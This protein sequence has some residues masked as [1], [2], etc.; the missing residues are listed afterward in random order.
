MK[1]AILISG[2]VDSSVAL[3]LLKQARH[4]VTAF[5]LK[6]WLED[7]LA[8]L[9]DCP[10][11]EDLKYA[12][13]VCDQLQVPLNVIPL[14]KEYWDRV[15]AYTIAEVKAG[16]T[17]SPDIMCNHHVKFGAFFDKIDAS[18]D[19]VATGH[20]A[21]TDMH[22]GKTRLL[23]AVDPIK[24][25]T[26]FLAR[27]TQQQLS[28]ALFP[29]GHL[30]KA[31]VRALAEK[32]NLA[33]QHRK[34]SQGICFLGKIKFDEFI[35][36]HL[37]KQP[38]KLIEFESGQTVGTHDGFW[39]YTIGQRKGIGL[40]GGPWYVVAKEPATN[41]VFISK[42]YFSEEKERNQFSV[43]AINWIAGVPPAKAQ[44]F[45][46]IRLLSL[47]A[48]FAQGERIGILATVRGEQSVAKSNPYERLNLSIK[49]RHG[50]HYYTGTLTLTNSTSGNVTINGNDQGIAPGQFA[51]FY[52][53]NVCLGCGTIQ[54]DAL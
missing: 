21:Q 12:Q 53:G 47:K 2:G 28:R 29:I 18:F 33:P 35:G 49:L 13:A 46:P 38:G 30:T 31:E 48:R 14:Q 40:S 37:G 22:E 16:H 7:E 20:Y 10:W 42:Q 24:D 26:Y 52:D 25:Q 32:Y 9:G 23:K 41:T 45:A 43:N 4:D 36:H 11:E 51:V 39:F 3:T 5:Y 44:A 34:D 27:L 1:I 17:P 19:K 50:E 15:V 54:N 6:I 8:Y